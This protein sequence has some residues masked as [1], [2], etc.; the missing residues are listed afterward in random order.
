MAK[1]KMAMNIHTTRLAIFAG[2]VTFAVGVISA[3]TDGYSYFQY[4]SES[5][6]NGYAS[7]DAWLAVA[8]AGGQGVSSTMPILTGAMTGSAVAAR[9]VEGRTRTWLE[10]TGKALRS[11]KFMGLGIILR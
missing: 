9:P 3:D 10:S 4:G 6:L 5:A 7:Y 11:D 8:N 2:L 1:T